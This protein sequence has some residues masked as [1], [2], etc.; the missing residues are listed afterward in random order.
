MVAL[1][2]TRTILG[3]KWSQLVSCKTFLFNVL[4]AIFCRFLFSFSNGVLGISSLVCPFLVVRVFWVIEVVGIFS[5]FYVL[6]RGYT[7]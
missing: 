2:S 4:I 1:D 7:G 3:R 5:V 6:A